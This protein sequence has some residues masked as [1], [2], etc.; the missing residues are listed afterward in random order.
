MV[1]EELLSRGEGKTLEFKRDL[2]SPKGLIKT[3]V[4]FSNTAGGKIIVGIDDS[5]KVIGVD[6]PLDE[7]ELLTLKLLRREQ[8]RLV[9]T[10]GGMLLF[11]RERV[12]H[13]PDAW[14]D[15]RRHEERCLQDP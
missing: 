3:L 13:Y 14:D 15:H 5:K 6:R 4:A 8:G 9:P 12:F 1:I 7:Q 2:S 10:R 11:G